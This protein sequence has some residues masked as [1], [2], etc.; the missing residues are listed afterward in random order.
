MRLIRHL[1]EQQVEYKQTEEMLATLKKDCG[2]YLK[3]AKKFQKGK[4]L[5]RGS[6]RS[7]KPNPKNGLEAKKVKKARIPRD[8]PLEIHYYLDDELKHKFGW[9]ARSEGVFATSSYMTAADFGIPYLFFPAGRYKYIYSPSVSDV[10]G[11]LDRL[12]VISFINNQYKIEPTLD[13]EDI[14]RELDN[15]IQTFTDK[16]LAKGVLEGAEIMFSCKY[17][18]LADRD[19]GIEIAKIIWG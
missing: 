2:P 5:Y 3:E 15:F 4:F 18:Y 19:D 9:S 6:L 12:G 14:E 10:L 16:N 8:I 1:N 11:A 17:Y 7:I 13:Q